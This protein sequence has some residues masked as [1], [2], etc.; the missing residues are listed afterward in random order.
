MSPQTPLP[1]PPSLPEMPPTP[2]DFALPTQSEI[3]PFTSKKINI[4]K[5]GILIPAA[6]TAAVCALLF[7]VNQFT[8]IMDITGAYIIFVM[9]YAAYIYSGVKKSV[10]VYIIPCVIVYAELNSAIFSFFIYI[11][12]VL[13]PG[14]DIPDGSGFVAQ[15]VNM[16]FGAGLCEELTKAV[17]ALIGLLIATRFAEGKPADFAPLD[18]MKVTSPLEGMMIGLAAGAMF[19]YDE[20]LFQYVPNTI[21]EV[22]KSSGAGA[23][24]ANGFA[25]LLP[26]T[27]QGATGHMGWAAISGY[28]IGMAAR[29]PRSTIKLLAIGWL[30]P[31]VLHGFWNSAS[32]LGESGKWISSALTLFLFVGCFL[33]AKQ[34]EA[35]RGTKV[36]VPTES[37]IAGAG[38]LPLANDTMP[39]AQ[40]TAWSGL[41]HIV[42]AFIPKNIAPAATLAPVQP[43]AA[44]NPQTVPMPDPARI[45]PRFA[46]ANGAQRFGI[47]VGQTIDLSTLF[48]GAGLPAGTLAE[49]TVNPKDPNAMGLKNM[50]GIAWTAGLEGSAETRVEPGRNVRLIAGGH[51]QLG[52]VAIL[53]QAV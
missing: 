36:F 35:M 6:V 26:R 24:F 42:S 2:R 45:I 27:L 22:T 49:V 11:F 43:V 31:S 9:F 17:P 21:A 29:Y 46:L 37:I 28:F 25:L 39:E 33:K 47:L 3:L 16:F 51:I 34:L 44:L 30:V 15:F 4:A 1:G 23:G 20:T 48:P 5:S 10:L 38:P 32:A 7:T 18:W 12:R 19:I 53:V 13:L 40:S 14:G 50:T 52:T 41:A 8:T